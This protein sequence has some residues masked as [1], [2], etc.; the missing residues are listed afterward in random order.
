MQLLTSWILDNLDNPY[1]SHEEKA[2]FSKGTGLSAT[3]VLSMLC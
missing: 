2:E 1:P 3:Q